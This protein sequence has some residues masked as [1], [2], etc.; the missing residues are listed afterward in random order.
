[1][2]ID[3]PKS[4]GVRNRLMTGAQLGIAVVAA[5]SVAILAF[6]PA[7][8]LRTLPRY[9]L[10]ARHLPARE[11]DGADPIYIHVGDP[12][13]AEVDTAAIRRGGALVP[14]DAIYYLETAVPNRTTANIVLAAQL[15]FLPAVQ[16]QKPRLA[17][18]VLSYRVRTSNSA[19][20]RVY[21]LDRDLRLARVR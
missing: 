8:L 1:M 13:A 3:L 21:T 10:V 2:K 6:Y 16:A 12:K 20:R 19:S 9:A 17:D 5:G 4:I 18:W 7:R 14:D 15:F 11:L